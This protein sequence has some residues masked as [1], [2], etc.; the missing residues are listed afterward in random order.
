LPVVGDRMA[1]DHSSPGRAEAATLTARSRLREPDAGT[2][3][4]IISTA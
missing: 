3:A 4:R 2:G 1:G